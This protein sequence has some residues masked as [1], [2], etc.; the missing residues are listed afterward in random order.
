MARRN[1]TVEDLYRNMNHF[2]HKTHSLI[3]VHKEC[4]RKKGEDLKVSLKDTGF[5]LDLFQKWRS[6]TV[7]DTCI[8]NLYIE[9]LCEYRDLFRLQEVL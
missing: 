7:I 9:R 5:P 8:F 6:R 4:C 1:D 2:Y 3:L